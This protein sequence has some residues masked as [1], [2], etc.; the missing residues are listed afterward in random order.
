MTTDSITLKKK[1]KATP[2]SCFPT[3]SFQ[4]FY[5][6]QSS[7][8]Y[9]YQKGGGGRGLLKDRT[10]PLFCQKAQ[11]PWERKCMSR[12]T[13]P[14]INSAISTLAAMWMGR[15]TAVFPS[16]RIRLYSWA[17]MQSKQ[18]QL[19]YHCRFVVLTDCPYNSQV[20]SR[21]TKFTLAYYEVVKYC[22]LSVCPCRLRH[23]PIKSCSSWLYLWLLQCLYARHFYKRPTTIWRLLTKNL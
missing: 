10:H 11:E 19:K 13:T 6:Y 4:I 21:Y 7:V 15:N 17:A 23:Q 12:V 20:F 18:E 14:E 22:F 1:K 9:F 3:T 8:F 2:V 5:F 16:R